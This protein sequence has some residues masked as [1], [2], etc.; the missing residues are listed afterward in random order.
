MRAVR[1][2]KDEGMS[3]GGASASSRLLE[4]D[5]M[6]ESHDTEGGGSGWVTIAIKLPDRSA[7]RKF[8]VTQRV[9]VRVSVYSFIHCNYTVVSIYNSEA[10][11]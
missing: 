8:R 7:R 5:D 1:G 9:R 3:L 11:V 2:L 6:E 4:S 10:T